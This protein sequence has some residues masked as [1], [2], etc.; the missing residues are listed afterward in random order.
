M[1]HADFLYKLWSGHNGAKTKI[2]TKTKTTTTGKAAKMISMF[3]IACGLLLTNCAKDGKTG[4]AGPTGPA[5]TNGTNG[6]ANVVSYKFV[7]SSWTSQTTYW[8]YSGTVP[9]ISSSTLNDG[10]AVLCYFSANNGTTWF[11]MPYTQVDA[12]SNYYM[13]FN[14][15]NGGITVFWQRDNGSL[16][17]NPNTYYG[18]TINVK[19]VVIPPAMRKPNVNVKNYDDI[20]AAYNL[21]D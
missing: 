12:T 17:S 3:A 10:S 18:Q 2:M 4:P 21:A 16:G 11:A 5:G 8:T 1:S 15:F 7:I 9:A 20:K 13:Y 14:T 19:T 6:N